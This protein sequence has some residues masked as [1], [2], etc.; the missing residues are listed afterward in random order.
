MQI[1]PISLDLSLSMEITEFENLD[2][3]DYIYMS[4]STR[5]ASIISLADFMDK[6]LVS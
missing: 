5:V 6:Q 3:E 4:V 1:G 2:L